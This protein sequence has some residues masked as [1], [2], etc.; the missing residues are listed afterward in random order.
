M[1]AGRA[2]ESALDALHALLSETL[3]SELQAY[4]KN[5]VPVPPPLLA[6][7]IKFL[8][9]NGIDSP[10]RAKKVLD[11]LKDEMPDFDD[12]PSPHIGAHH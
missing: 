3:Q 12:D 7:C 2:T 6:Q 10:A 1:S 5:G 11:T 4:R 8:K 9:D